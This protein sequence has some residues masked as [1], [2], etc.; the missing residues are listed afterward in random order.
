M[1]GSEGPRGSY[2]I[3]HDNE[4]AIL[5]YKLSGTKCPWAK[6]YNLT[7]FLSDLLIYFWYIPIFFSARGQIHP[8][9]H[10]LLYNLCDLVSEE[11]NNGVSGQFWNKI[12]LSSQCTVRLKKVQMAHFIILV[13]NRINFNFC[14]F[15]SV[16][17]FKF[18]W[19][20]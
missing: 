19:L 16:N 18:S 11:K 10:C 4:R 8:G 3:I 15:Q 9:C 2:S 14:G 6:F 7:D 17:V 1:R 5:F 20:S 12:Q 13:V